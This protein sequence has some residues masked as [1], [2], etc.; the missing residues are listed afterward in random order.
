VPGPTHLRLPPRAAIGSGEQ[1][2]R[3]G[4]RS[5]EGAATRPQK[6]PITSLSHRRRVFYGV[7]SP[8]PGSDIVG[9]VVRDG[10]EAEQFIA[11]VTSEPNPEDPVIAKALSVVEVEFGQPAE[12]SLS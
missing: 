7:R 9:R 10:A 3:S 8:G 5:P 11:E 4:R 2:L 12:A 1:D 6:S